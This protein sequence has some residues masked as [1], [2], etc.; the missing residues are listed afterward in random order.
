[1]KL[2]DSIQMDSER[3]LKL[4]NWQDCFNS[5][6]DLELKIATIFTILLC[7]NHT[8]RKT[9]LHKRVLHFLNVRTSQSPKI[10]F[11]KSIDKTIS[12]LI[13]GKIFRE[14]N[15]TKEHPRV[16]FDKTKTELFEGYLRRLFKD[17]ELT[18]RT[19]SNPV[20]TISNVYN[21]SNGIS[22]FE[23]DSFE[24]EDRSNYDELFDN[25]LETDES[26]DIENSIDEM[27]ENL[28]DKFLDDELPEIIENVPQRHDSVKSSYN[29]KEKILLHFSQ[30]KNITVD[31]DFSEI[32][33]NMNGNIETIA[34][35]EIDQLSNSLNCYVKIEYLFESTNP[36]L[37]AL[38][39]SYTNIT[40]CIDNIN[41]KEVFLLKQRIDIT[42]YN[43]QE[44]ISLIETLLK[45][46]RIVTNLI[47]KHL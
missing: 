44:I 43:E 47:E 9:L 17:E 13:V 37:K 40:L 46:S 19:I 31:D 38:S 33:I 1:M 7:P 42:R 2:Y 10:E 22:L 16:K 29:I 39:K 41:D 5:L 28:L 35:I 11:K 27:D 34:I 6:S 14:Y 18:K 45:T 4:K 24:N 26:Y 36:I 3:F 23:N 15:K 20:D 8:C 25:D 32:K 30:I 21:I 12:Q